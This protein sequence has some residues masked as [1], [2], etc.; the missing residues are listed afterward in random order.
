MG[1]PKEGKEEEERRTDG[2]TDG[3]TKPPQPAAAK[4]AERERSFP[5]GD[6]FVTRCDQL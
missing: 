3:Q 6:D 5:A 1:L 2:Q 4:T